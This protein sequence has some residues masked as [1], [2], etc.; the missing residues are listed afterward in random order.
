MANKEL[1]E[2]RKKAHSVLDPLWKRGGMPRKV[3]YQKLKKMF[4][5]EIHVGEAD[6]ATCQE[7]IKKIVAYQTPI[8]F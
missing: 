2:W 6:I 4:G 8:Q 3:L 1:R 5:R 7:V